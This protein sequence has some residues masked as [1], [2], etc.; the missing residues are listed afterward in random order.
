MSSIETN[1]FIQSFV[2]KERII[3]LIIGITG[4][5][6][7]KNDDYPK[8]KYSLIR[9][10]SSI[11]KDWQSKKGE[12]TGPIIVMTGLA[13]G[14]DMLT[15][16]VAL[17]MGLEVA[18][19]LPMP[20]QMYSGKYKGEKDLSR[21]KNLYSKSKFKIELPL[22]PE[23]GIKG[24][25]VQ[26]AALGDFI[27]AHSTMLIALWDGRVADKPGGTSDVVHLKLYGQ[28]A[29]DPESSDL[30]ALPPL[31]PVYQIITPREGMVKPKN[32]FRIKIWEPGLFSTK[33]R[34]LDKGEILPE[35][36][37]WLKNFNMDMR[38]AKDEPESLAKAAKM[39]FPEK[40]GL[41]LPPHLVS[42]YA[43]ADWLAGHFQNKAF[44]HVKI[45]MAIMGAIGLFFSAKSF[46]PYLDIPIFKLNIQ[47][48]SNLFDS[49]GIHRIQPDFTFTY[50]SLI[51]AGYSLASVGV[52]YCWI[53]KDFVKANEKYSH[54]RSLA[55]GLRVQ[56]FW[57]IAGIK[58]SVA[59]NYL[60][61]QV[62]SFNWIRYAIAAIHPRIE[63]SEVK[64]GLEYVN[65][66]WICDQ[67]DFYKK[68]SHIFNKKD[69]RIQTLVKSAIF[70]TIS[71]WMLKVMIG[72]IKSMSAAVAG[73]MQNHGLLAS[74]IV[75]VLA[76]LSF[77]APVIY[78]YQSYRNYADNARRYAL[79]VPLLT[80]AKNILEHEIKKG[81]TVKARKTLLQLGRQ[82]LSENADWLIRRM[83]IKIDAP[84]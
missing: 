72:D 26:Y 38:L 53:A 27:A 75:F 62:T 60:N 79:M 3:P 19:V 35:G 44:F 34:F 5:R 58:E 2:S 56:I 20:E 25:E 80:K 50:T 73:L 43:H 71:F 74:S 51:T 64:P 47:Q 63:R 69:S 82:A 36:A 31:G 66:N 14:G 9:L 33:S 45:Y 29:P 18:S 30:F 17:E 52:L 37:V 77:A 1:T 76:S 41:K 70:F 8:I 40:E 22:L 61:H 59:D 7:I 28:S 6:N 24:D 65:Q 57:H 46:A 32:A 83:K 54:Y 39:T 49:M 10:L 84:K 12:N 81:E 15:T 21:F 23:H 78:T 13:I 11:R 16:E 4:H 67:L 48:I 55:E 42:L 68:K